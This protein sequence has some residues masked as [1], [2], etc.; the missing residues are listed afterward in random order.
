MDRAWCSIESQLV[1]PVGDVMIP[2]IS[3]IIY[4]VRLICLDAHH[5]RNGCRLD[6]ELFLMYD[7]HMCMSMRKTV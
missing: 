5:R 7:V 1:F 2:I 4:T 3:I 6:E